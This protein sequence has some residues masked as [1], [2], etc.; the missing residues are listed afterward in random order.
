M[1]GKIGWIE[2]YAK[3][4]GKLA[5]FYE[6]VF[7]WKIQKDPSM[8]EYVMFSDS[9]GDVAGGF[10]TEMPKA[11][12]HIYLLTDDIDQSL[13]A[14]KAAGGKTVKEKTLITKEIGYWGQFQDPQ[15]NKVGLFEQVAR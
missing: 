6:H 1:N 7:G 12:G 10:S 4:G 11:A 2:L 8:P 9:S 3:D 15:G 14:V 13:K 5:D